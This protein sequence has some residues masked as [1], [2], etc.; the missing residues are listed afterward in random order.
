M[1]TNRKQ[2][3]LDALLKS[4]TQKVIQ[5]AVRSLPEESLSLSW[6]SDLNERLRQV[7][8]VSR[9]RARL[10]IV[11]KPALGVAL[12]SC[13]ALVLTLRTTPITQKPTDSNLEASMV[14]VYNDSANADE[15]SDSGLA[16]HEI[17]D[18]TSTSTTSDS[19][20]T[21]WSESDLSS[22]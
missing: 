19:S 2:S 13:L 11:W 4:E 1:N 14:S 3:E 8:P 18:T 10:T 21:N 6:R 16:F 12:A 20:S 5:R 15:V 7:R 17:N 22:L 9:W